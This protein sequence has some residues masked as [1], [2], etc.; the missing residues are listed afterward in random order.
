M[1]VA[2]ISDVH[3]NLQALTAVLAEIDRDALEAVICAGD[4]VGYG[5]NPNE[6]CGLLA[7]RCRGIVLGN[8]DHSALTGDTCLMN[9][10]A[11]RASVWTARALSERSRSF[12]ASL[13]K[14]AFIGIGGSSLAM[15]HGS[16]RSMSEYIYETD[17]DEGIMESA[18]SDLLVL[19]HTHVPYIVR[20]GHGLAINPGSV[21]QPR[22]GDPRA[23]YAVL[24]VPRLECE[25]RRLD[26]D[27]DGAAKAIMGAGL[28]ELLADRLYAGM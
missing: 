8:H 11:A 2:I 5:A 16:P 21:G 4:I 22:D 10:Y 20:F 12:L 17:M 18:R 9:P 28:P 3:S 27:I 23:S 13:P 25:I 26:Y 24:D 7:D 15:Y 14:E 1:R 19:G 6:C